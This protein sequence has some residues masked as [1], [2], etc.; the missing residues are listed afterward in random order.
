MKEPVED[1]P[2]N[3]YLTTWILLKRVNDTLIKVRNRELRQHDINLEYKGTLHAVRRLGTRATPGEIA[4]L[5]CRRPHTIS[6][7]LKNM[8]KDGLVT[9]NKDLS[10]K[11]MV[12]IALTEKGENISPRMVKS[13]TVSKILSSL[14][15]EEKIKLHTYLEMLQS[16]ATYKF[17]IDFK[18]ML[19][20]PHSRSSESEINLQ[21]VFKR[22]NDIV[23]DIASVLN[24]AEPDKVNP[25]TEKT[26]GYNMV[27]AALQSS[28]FLPERLQQL[29]EYLEV[30]RSTTT[31]LKH[32]HGK[33]LSAKKYGAGEIESA[34]WRKIRR[35][36]DIIIRISD[37]EMASHGFSAKLASVLLAV[38]TLGDKATL[39]EIARWR[40]RNASTMSS[41]LKSLE[42]QGLVRKLDSAKK[43]QNNRI[44]LTEKGE[45]Y[46]NQSIRTES[47]AQIYS[48]FSTEELAQFSSYLETTRDR[49]VKELS[50]LMA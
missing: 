17:A 25:A 32:R 6:Q 41:F 15:Q 36:H 10:R 22:T 27:R 24:H 14:S 11:N 28:T 30:L 2:V 40:M 33:A 3:Q 35:T 37:K 38:K 20:E 8:E 50:N 31:R 9:R 12:R 1:V 5:R 23:T 19:P 29:N 16:E 45:K 43:S 44:A 47:V 42:K 39:S 18:T 21:R 4:R 46:F 26:H 49:A 7:V 34:L 13:V 48:I